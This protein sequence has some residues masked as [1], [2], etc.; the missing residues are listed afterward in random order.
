MMELV[1]PAGTP[2]ALRA[3]VEAGAHAVYCG[4][5]DET[6]ARNFP[7]L[8]FSPEE[9]VKTPGGTQC[10]HWQ[11]ILILRCNSTANK[12]HAFHSSSLTRG[13]MWVGS[14]YPAGP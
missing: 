11:V 12:R 9:S 1:C 5:A 6:N 8:N 7:G 14:L 13:G 3:A 2:A 10:T 4:F